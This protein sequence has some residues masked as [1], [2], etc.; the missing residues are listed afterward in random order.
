VPL[1]EVV[2]ALRAVG[3]DGDYDVELVGQEIEATDYRE[4]LRHSKAA[5][6]GLIG[7]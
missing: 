3:Y 7:T 6:D 4:L 1:R 2:A 5:F